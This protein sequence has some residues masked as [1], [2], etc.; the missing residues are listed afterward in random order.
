MSELNWQKSTF[1]GGPEADCLYVATAPDGTIRLRESD[2]PNV[3]L[4]TAPEGLAALLRHLRTAIP[5][6][7]ER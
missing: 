5:P 3:I 4:S 2:T 1:S 6:I 7:Q